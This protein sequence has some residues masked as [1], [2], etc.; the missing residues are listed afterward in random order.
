MAGTRGMR[1]FE[2][3]D[4]RSPLLAKAARSFGKLRTGSFGFARGK[5][6]APDRVILAPGFDNLSQR[7]GHLERAVQFFHLG[8]RQRSDE[9]AQLHFSQAYKVVAQNP[10]FVFQA[11]LNADRNLG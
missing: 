3:K 2:G 7:E 10:A 9:M 4:R 11:F 1:G 6:G 8:A 5:N